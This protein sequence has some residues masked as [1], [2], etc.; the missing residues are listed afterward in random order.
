MYRELYQKLLNK[1]TKLSLV[2][3]GYAYSSSFCE[4]DQCCR[5]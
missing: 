4:E 1:E 5:L 3:L 2:G